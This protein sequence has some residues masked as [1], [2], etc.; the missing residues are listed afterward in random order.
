MEAGEVMTIRVRTNNVPRPVIDASELTAVERGRFD[1][2]DWPAIDEGCDSASFVRYRGDLIYLGEFLRS[3][4][5]GELRVAG[6]HGILSDSA[7]TATVIK[8]ADDGES[9]VVGYLT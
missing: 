3:D 4:P 8:L 2:L 6:W 5:I 9:A 7:F 1:Y